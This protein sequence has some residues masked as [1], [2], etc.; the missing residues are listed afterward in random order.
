[1]TQEYRL[2]KGQQRAVVA[3]MRERDQLIARVQQQVAEIGEALQELA[4][5]YARGFGIAGTATFAQP[6]GP[7]GQIVLVMEPAEAVEAVMPEEG[8]S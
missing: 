5:T 7:G 3:L 8:N 2:S 4:E 6:T 1:L